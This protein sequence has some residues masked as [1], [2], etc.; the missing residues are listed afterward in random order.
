MR[1]SFDKLIIGFIAETIEKFSRENLDRSLGHLQIFSK[2]STIKLSAMQ[3]YTKHT[4]VVEVY[5]SKPRNYQESIS[6][7]KI[8]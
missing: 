6:H 7:D 3:Y 2:F 1:K 5:S 4:G 8:F